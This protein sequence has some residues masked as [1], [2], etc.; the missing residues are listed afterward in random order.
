MCRVFFFYLYKDIQGEEDILEGV[1]MKDKL[2]IKSELIL[3]VPTS[4][5][6]SR[7]IYAHF[8]LFGNGGGTLQQPCT[9]SIL[10]NVC[11]FVEKC[12]KKLL[13]KIFFYVVET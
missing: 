10:W 13:E 7:S 3:Q 2:T 12:P 6:N 8:G 9:M 5:W 1:G 4:K 11:D